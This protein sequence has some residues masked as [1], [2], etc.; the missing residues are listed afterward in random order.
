MVWDSMVHVSGIRCQEGRRA[1]QLPLS[2]LCAL[3]LVSMHLA[4]MTDP[5][6]G[7]QLCERQDCGLAKRS[8]KLASAL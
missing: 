8:K 4:D 5:A 2:L 3:G 7:Q 6:T 1:G